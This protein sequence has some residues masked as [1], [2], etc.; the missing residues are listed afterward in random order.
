MFNCIRKIINAS[1]ELIYIYSSITKKSSKNFL[2]DFSV[3][4]LRHSTHNNSKT[5][6]QALI[7][8]GT[9]AVM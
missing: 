8:F 2:I 1:Y 3:F 5:A 6:E 7:E 4:A 9:G